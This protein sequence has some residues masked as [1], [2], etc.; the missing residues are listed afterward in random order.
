MCVGVC[1]DVCVHNIFSLKLAYA[2]RAVDCAIRTQDWKASSGQFFG[3]GQL[4][5]LETM[6]EQQLARSQGVGHVGT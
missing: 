3:L 6:L 5:L 1:I 2:S 4:G